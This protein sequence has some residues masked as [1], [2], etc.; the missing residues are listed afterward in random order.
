MMNNADWTA[1][2]GSALARGNLGGYARPLNPKLLA[3]QGAK[4]KP[5]TSTAS[6]RRARKLIVQAHRLAGEVDDLVLRSCKPATRGPALWELN[7]PGAAG[8]RAYARQVALL[9]RWHGLP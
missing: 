8:Q 6:A 2:T 7:Q 3:R 4:S 1:A 9:Q 5:A